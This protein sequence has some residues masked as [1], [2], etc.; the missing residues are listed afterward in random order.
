MSLSQDTQDG[1]RTHSLILR[2]PEE[3]S[4]PAKNKSNKRRKSSYQRQKDT[5]RLLFWNEKEKTEKRD[6]LGSA[7]TEPEPPN[8]S[9]ESVE[10]E[11]EPPYIHK[12]S[13]PTAQ[14]P[15]T[16]AKKFIPHDREEYLC[17]HCFINWNRTVRMAN[18]FFFR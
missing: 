8:H 15:S 4:F 6:S 11:P 14:D 5:A 9:N 12:D 1:Q 7:Q 13:T 16:N 17:R 10:T 3:V 2:V 18:G